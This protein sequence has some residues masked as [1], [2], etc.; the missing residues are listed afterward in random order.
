MDNVKI[1]LLKNGNL[2]DYL[3]GRVQ[4]LDEEPSVFIEKCYRMVGD[5]MEPYPRYSKQRDLFLT[6]DSIFTIV[7]PNKAVL[8]LYLEKEKSEPVV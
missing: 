7:D 5:D 6:S 8:E 3:V 4:E 1:L 2:N